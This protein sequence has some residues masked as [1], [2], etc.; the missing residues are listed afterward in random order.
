MYVLLIII[1]DKP[2]LK[3]LFRQLCPLAAEWKN[4]GCL[5]GLQTHDLNRISRD[6]ESV[7]DR[8][9]V[10]LTEYLHQVDPSPTWKAIIDAVEAI[11]SNKATEINANLA[12]NY[13][14]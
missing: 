6:E 1:D 10:M 12:H 7:R 13:S 9:R 11:D 14:Q 3:D 4:I 5:L 2:E 8:L